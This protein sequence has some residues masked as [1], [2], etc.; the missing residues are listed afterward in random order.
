MAT[1]RLQKILS[2]LKRELGGKVE[3]ES[4][5]SKRAKEMAA[6]SRRPYL[7]ADVFNQERSVKTSHFKTL[8][9]RQK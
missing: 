6:N 4:Y 5:D 9:A 3:E 8:D 7:I 2:D 1:I